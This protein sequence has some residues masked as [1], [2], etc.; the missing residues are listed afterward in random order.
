MPR[1]PKLEITADE[2]QACRAAWYE[3]HYNARQYVKALPD[4]IRRL[5]QNVCNTIVS[6]PTLTVYGG[7]PHDWPPAD[8]FYLAVKHGLDGN[9][10]NPWYLTEPGWEDFQRLWKQLP[11]PINLYPQG[12]VQIGPVVLSVHNLAEETPPQR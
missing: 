5:Y 6:P 10:I 11:E 7:V 8:A 4:Y 3:Y 9:Y 12:C 1:N 2:I